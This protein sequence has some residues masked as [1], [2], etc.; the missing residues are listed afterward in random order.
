MKQRKGSLVAVLSGALGLCELQQGLRAAQ[1]IVEHL[2]L[3]LEE[4]VV[5][6]LTNQRRTPDLINNLGEVIL[7]YLVDEL[8]S[9]ADSEHP[10]AIGQ[11]PARRTDRK[12]TRLN[13]SH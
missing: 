4:L 2:R 11:R 8:R 13:S 10:Q 5:F 6:G 7:V 9:R 1:C 3:S 12:S